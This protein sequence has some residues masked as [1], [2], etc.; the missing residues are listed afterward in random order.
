MYVA[1][2]DRRR[3]LEEI[4]QEDDWDSLDQA[5]PTITGVSDDAEEPAVES[6]N[7]LTRLRRLMQR[8]IKA[9]DY[10]KAASLRDEISRLES[11]GE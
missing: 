3:Q 2:C 4:S 11:G 1:L 7:Q 5:E 9:E 8:A 6:E 10:E